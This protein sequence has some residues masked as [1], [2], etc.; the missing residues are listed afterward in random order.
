MLQRPY[1]QQLL[2]P[3][4]LSCFRWFIIWPCF[5]STQAFTTCTPSFSSEDMD[6]HSLPLSFFP[7]LPST[8]PL[9]CS[10][11]SDDRPLLC[12]TL[13]PASEFANVPLPSWMFS[14]P[15]PLTYILPTFQT[16]LKPHC[17]E[18]A[19]VYLNPHWFLPSLNF[20]RWHLLC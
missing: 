13:V 9:L 8:C 19:S 14:C 16:V 12:S 18:A 4:K 2:S 17:H 11:M 1:C 5:L 6:T 15:T 7:F 20:Y 10:C 3:S